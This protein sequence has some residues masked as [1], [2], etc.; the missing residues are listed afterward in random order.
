MG[1]VERE[2]ARFWDT[3]SYVDVKRGDVPEM[4]GARVM[5]G[6][7]GAYSAAWMLRWAHEHSPAHLRTSELYWADAYSECWEAAAELGL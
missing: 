5:F 2:L 3:C 1:P 4:T 7:V 6:A